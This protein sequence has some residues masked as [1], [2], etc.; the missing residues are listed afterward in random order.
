MHVMLFTIILADWVKYVADT[1]STYDKIVHNNS[2]M[3]KEVY[4]IVRIS[5]VHLFIE[6][7]CMISSMDDHDSSKSRRSRT[8]H[9]ICL[10]SVGVSLEQTKYIR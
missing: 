2:L 10:K 6:I 8:V 4:S 1:E 3:I 7:V 5:T 9:F